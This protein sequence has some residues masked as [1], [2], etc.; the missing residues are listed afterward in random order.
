M[1]TNYSI[2][3]W[4]ALLAL[5]GLGLQ[6][7][8]LAQ[9]Y[10]IL[11]LGTLGGNYSEARGI[12]NSGQ[13]VGLANTADGNGHAFLYSGGVMTDLGALGGGS[14]Y[15]NGI[16]DS[17]QVVGCA[18]TATSSHAFLYSGGVMTDLGHSGRQAKQ[19]PR[20]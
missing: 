13:V 2:P 4:L 15:A 8:A 19:R 6:I 1:K 9:S 17:G 12:N 5:A 7:S 18:D 20:H 11:D 3:R 14:S 16:N 10:S